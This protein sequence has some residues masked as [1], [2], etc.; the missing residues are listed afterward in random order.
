M[1][2]ILFQIGPIT[3]YSYGV[4]L[5]TAVVICAWLLSRDAKKLGIGHETI[6]DLMLWTVAGGIIGARLFYVAI[7]WEYFSSQWMEIF[8]IYKGG[9]A[10]QGS[11]V[12]G[13]VGGVLFARRR[14]LSLRPLTDIVAPYIALGQSIGRVGCFFNGCCFGRHFDFGIYFPVHQDKLHPTQLYE[15][16]LLALIFFVLK[17]LQ[18]RK[19]PSGSIFAWYLLLAGLER[20]TVEFWR[21]DHVTTFLGLSMA[22]FISLGLVAAGLGLHRY[23]C[24]RGN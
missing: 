22:Q 5:A 4:M 2:P 8:L 20:F 19:H 15:V 21:A 3:I 17:H 10:W 24:S 6:Y 1:H 23:Y 12:G 9:L 16:G 11:F 14:A 13:V 7:S 18:Q